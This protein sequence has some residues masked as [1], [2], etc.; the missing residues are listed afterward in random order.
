MRHLLLGAL[1][2]ASLG[3]FG[4][5]GDFSN[6]D[7]EFL[8]ALPE[9]KVLAAAL[10]DAPQNAAALD[11]SVS[12]LALGETSKLYADTRR[13]STEFNRGVDGLLALLEGIRSVPPTTRAPGAR[14]WGPYPDKQHPGMDVRFLMTRQLARFTYSLQYRRTG[15]GEDAWWSLIEGEFNASAGIRKG[16]GSV[17]LLISE[18]RAR[19]Y[20]QG[21]LSGLDTLSIGYQ[22]L[23]QPV[24][25]EEIFDFA[26]GT[27]GP[28][29]VRYTYR[30]FTDGPGEMHFVIRDTQATP[31][32][33]LETLDITSRW[34]ASQGGAGSV[35]VLSGDYAG[36]RSVEC[37]NGAGQTVFERANWDPFGGSGELR[38]CPDL[39]A[40]GALPGT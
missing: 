5:G 16:E 24:R 15:E 26:A 11:G 29:E 32:T 9:R 18:A 37:W 1:V 31:G 30:A 3:S 34:T 10:P 19:G 21:D 7:L 14:T 33:A 28:S 25:V 23:T 8:N 38:A 36:A 12:A 22:T 27:T 17:S 35:L 40:F 20:A 13:V 4:C 2:L 39:S 6:E